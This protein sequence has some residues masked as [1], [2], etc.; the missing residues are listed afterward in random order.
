MTE[1]RNGEGSGG[2]GDWGE[3]PKWDEGI[4]VIK[5]REHISWTREDTN[6]TYIGMHTQQIDPYIRLV[7]YN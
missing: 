3:V 1:G 7:N 5:K 4:R 2:G 6:D